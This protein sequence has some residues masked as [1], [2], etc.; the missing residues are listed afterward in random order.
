[1]MPLILINRSGSCKFMVLIWLENV[2]AQMTA[3]TKVLGRSVPGMCKEGTV[4]GIE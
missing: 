1:M 4:P 3:S 2:D